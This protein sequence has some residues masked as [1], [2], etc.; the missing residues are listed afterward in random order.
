MSQHTTNIHAFVAAANSS[1][2]EV[3]KAYCGMVAIELVLK[4][5]TGLTDH[6]VPSALNI[7]AHR[8]AVGHLQGCK[9]RLD[10]LSVQLKNALK[11]ISVQGKDGMARYAPAESYPYIRYTRLAV[12]GWPA[13]VTTNEQVDA[14]ASAVGG[15]RAYLKDKF[16]K[17]L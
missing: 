13:P 2:D 7:F 17:P 8:F 6:N 5:S 12:D 1:V 16:Q 3:I 11:A 9:I 14:L 10:A 4:Q 15:T